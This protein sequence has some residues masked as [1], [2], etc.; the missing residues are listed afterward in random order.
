MIGGSQGG[1]AGGSGA[2]RI[3]VVMNT[4]VNIVSYVHQVFAEL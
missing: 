4:W 1:S 2:I 3:A